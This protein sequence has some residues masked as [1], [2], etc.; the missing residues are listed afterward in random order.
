LI[1][2]ELRRAAAL[3]FVADLSE[4]EP[5]P[6]DAHHL[7]DVLR[8]RD[9]EAVAAG[10]GDGRYRMCRFVRGAGRDRAAAL[11][12]SGEVV[13]LEAPARRVG[14][15]FALQKGDRPDW[16]AQKLTELGVDDLYPMLTRRSVVR[17]DPPAAQRR[18][19][20][21]RRVAREASA[22]ARRTRL[23]HVHEIA[24]YDELVPALRE[25]LG[26][27]LALADPD[28]VALSAQTTH[29][30]VGPEGG[31]DATELDMIK[32]RV[33]LATLVLRAETAAVA[34]GCLLA[35]ARDGDG[36]LVPVR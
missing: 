6:G 30:L 18:V 29:V 15:G 26:D 9:G 21:L 17:L 36:A 33:S 19:E 34:A 35:A 11:A 28:G 4:P 3:V 14:V 16:T 25:G 1:P 22:Q 7:R 23:P 20:R 32:I 27:G 31:F 10:D 2:A 24:A 5:E 13:E 12:P 8:L